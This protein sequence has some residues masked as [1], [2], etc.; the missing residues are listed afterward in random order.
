MMDDE[1]AIRHLQRKGLWPRVDT[2]HL[3]RALESVAL[4]YECMGLAI[5]WEEKLNA[6]SEVGVWRCM[7]S[8]F[9]GSATVYG[10]MWPEFSAACEKLVCGDRRNRW[11]FWEK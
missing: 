2:F 5:R 8:S 10:Y 6:A 7:P 4:T 3:G 9:N 1:R 11:E